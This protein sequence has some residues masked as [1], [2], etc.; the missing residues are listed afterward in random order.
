MSEDLKPFLMRALTKLDK[1]S[2]E[3]KR[4]SPLSQED[5]KILLLRELVKEQLPNEDTGSTTHATR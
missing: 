1:L 3:I 2:L 5:Q 4:T